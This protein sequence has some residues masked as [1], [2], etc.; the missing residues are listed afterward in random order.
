MTIRQ[1]VI[2]RLVVGFALLF[3]VSALTF[4]LVALIPSDPARSILGNT[5]TAQ[6][7]TALRSQ[8]GLDRPLW[9]QYAS[10][11]GHALRGDLGSSLIAPQSVASTLNADLSVTLPLTVGAVLVTM[12]VGVAAGTL[13][14]LRGGVVA[15]LIDLVALT[16]LALPSFWVALVLGEYFGVRLHWLPAT[17]FVAFADS[18]LGWLRSLVLPVVAVAVGG[19]AA[20]AKQTR[21]SVDGVL[22]QEYIRALRADGL[23]LRRLLFLHVLRNAAI[24]VVAVGGTQF[25]AVLGGTVIVENVFA[26]PGLGSTVVRA[27]LDHDLPLIVGAAVY[28]CALVVLANLLVDVVFALINPKLRNVS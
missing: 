13:A 20:V 21:E 8:L 24:P 19:V 23:P 1:L 25:V 9:A 16:G 27:A 10:W 7:I 26:L 17:G 14:A 11:A 28:F 5:A 2:R 6:Q 3:V 18:P 12:T 22:R 15:R 4:V